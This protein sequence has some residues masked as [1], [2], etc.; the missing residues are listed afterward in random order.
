MN[1]YTRAQAELIT[2]ANPEDPTLR[3]RV[4]ARG[5]A[6]R[7]TGFGNAFVDLVLGLLKLGADVRLKPLHTHPPLPPEFLACMLDPW[8][9][10]APVAIDMTNLTN[11]ERTAQHTI[12]ITMWET[13]SLPPKARRRL[14]AA[15]EFIVPC[16]DN[17]A[18][19]QKYEPDKKVRFVPI[20]V[21]ADFWTLRDRTWNSSPLKI[22]MIGDLNVRKGIDLGVEAFVKAFD[23][24]PSVE[25]HIATSSNHF[26][27]FHIQELNPNIHVELFGYRTR[28]QVRDWYYGKHALLAPFRGEGFYL[29]GAEFTATG[30]C[31]IAP[32]MMGTSYYHSDA[33]GWVIPSKFVDVGHWPPY[34]GKAAADELGQ[35]VGYGDSLAEEIDT[36]ASTLVAFAN[37]SAS[38]KRTRAYA[39]A[40]EI[41]FLCDPVSVAQ[42]TLDTFLEAHL[43]A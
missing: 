10:D 3:A 6:N 27:L 24:D 34:Y 38:E 30:G 15:T 17:V 29:P 20:G 36:V 21:D 42:Q 35:W 2:H 12:S 9:N 19:I 1:R 32:K 5:V 16:E 37:A 40:G 11:L 4:P 43:D 25:L 28:D 8:D 31:L 22:G 33:K 13:T 14:S 18:L 26:P 41:P 39:A 23:N 7:N